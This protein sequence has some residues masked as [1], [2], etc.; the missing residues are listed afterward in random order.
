MLAKRLPGSRNFG[1]QKFLA[2]LNLCG[3]PVRWSTTS[4]LTA[5][6]GW[7][8]RRGGVY[9]EHPVGSSNLYLARFRRTAEIWIKLGLSKYVQS[10][11]AGRVSF[12][13]RIL[14]WSPEIEVVLQIYLQALHS[15]PCPFP[16]TAF[17]SHA[18]LKTRQCNRSGSSFISS[19]LLI[20]STILSVCEWNRS[21]LI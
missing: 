13:S 3:R 1:F 8:R 10:R 5:Q 17:Q 4:I 18:F 21:G 14:H 19:I 11:Y 6:L 15:F 12:S 2:S 20:N 7:T 9:N 16:H